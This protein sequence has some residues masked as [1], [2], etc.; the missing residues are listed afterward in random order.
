MFYDGD[1][2]RSKVVGVLRGKFL[3]LVIHSTS[4]MSVFAPG[5]TASFCTCVLNVA[6]YIQLH[7]DIF[8]HTAKQAL[9]TGSA[10]P[11]PSFRRGPVFNATPGR[12]CDFGRD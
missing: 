4:L 12:G 1:F 2:F 3:N 8:I 5:L 7:F 6:Y 9:S 11:R 10:S